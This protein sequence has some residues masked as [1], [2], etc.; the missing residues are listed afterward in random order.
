MATTEW[1]RE[2]NNVHINIPKKDKKVEE[3]IEEKIDIDSK[4][5]IFDRVIV[6]FN[7]SKFFMGTAIFLIILGISIS[8]YNYDF[9][10]FT[11]INGENTTITIPLSI[12]NIASNDNYMFMILFGF[13]III[14]IF[15]KFFRIKNHF[16]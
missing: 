9:K 15:Y 14:L 7:V 12:A 2:D 3:D 13:P 5:D 1:L 6:D 4:E 8:L 10:I 11:S 16:Y